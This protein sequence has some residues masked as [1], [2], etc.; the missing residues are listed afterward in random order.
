MSMFKLVGIA[1]T[2]WKLASKR[3]GP[4]AG[5]VA[6]V[7][8]VAAFVFVQNYLEEHYPALGDAVEKAV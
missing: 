7:A 2:A 5:L 4:V 1:W 8:V 6:A 3:L